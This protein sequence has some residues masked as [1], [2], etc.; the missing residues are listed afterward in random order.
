MHLKIYVDLQ[1]AST[2]EANE[3]EGAVE[4]TEVDCSEYEHECCFRQLGKRSIQVRS[5]NETEICLSAIIHK[6]QFSTN[7]Q[8]NVGQEAL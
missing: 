8:W 3:A 5:G 4:H 6:V 7:A 2:T 1:G